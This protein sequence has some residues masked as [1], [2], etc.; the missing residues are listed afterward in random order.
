MDVVER[1]RAV[2]WDLSPVPIERRVMSALDTAVL[3]GDLSIGVLVLV[4]GGLLV[5]AMSIPT[6][7]VAIVLG[8]IMGSLLLA[9]A[10][11]I[12]AR[13]GVPAMVLLRGALGRRGSWV[14]SALNALQ[15]I[16]WTAVE[17]WAMSRVADVIS[18]RVFGF[19]ARGLWLVVVSLACTAM[20]LWGPL[21]V[22]HVWLKRFGAW[23][24]G[25]LT[26]IVTLLVF[27]SGGISEALG[28]PGAGGLG[29]GTALDLVIALPVSWMPLVADYTRFSARPRAAFAGTFWGY[30]VG[31]VW[32]YALGAL[33]VSSG[34]EAS[35]TGM[36]AAIAALAG[37]SVAGVLFLGG[38]LAVETD[39]AFADLY[40]AVL[41]IRNIDP[42]PS[43][44]V[45][46]VLIAS[47]S[48][49]LAWR[50][51]MHHYETFLL[52][53]GSVFIPLFGV[54]L[55]RGLSSRTHGEKGSRRLG[56]SGSFAAWLVGFIAYHWVLPTGPGWWTD[57]VGRLLGTPVSSDV[58]WLS[59][60]LV[61][62]AV[63]FL[64]SL[65]LAR[66]ERRISSSRH[67]I[68]PR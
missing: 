16:G 32:L 51:D 33:L 43:H 9:A 19:S 42:R 8:S 28:A 54:V 65:A 25:A 55:A 18:V 36:A 30:L 41:S 58:P 50:L 21:Q 23:F 39:E 45:L 7:L 68:N 61:A 63:S 10:G 60:S 64:P 12:G 34:G 37:G 4:A 17:L 22:V 59:A 26:L 46:T 56:R 62:L 57:L 11:Y 29:F 35:P 67:H 38:L 52:L 48:A 44:R 27:A 66:S 40:S 3:W 49:A 6:A 5:P 20:A 1:D 14:P 47:V 13:E 2:Q 53:L 31:N 15:L 24:V